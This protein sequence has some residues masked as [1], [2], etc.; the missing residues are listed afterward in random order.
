MSEEWFAAAGEQ[1]ESAA[2][3]LPKTCQLAKFLSSGGHGG[4]RLIET[5]YTAIPERAE[6]IVLELDVEVGQQPIHDIR[7]VER[8]AVTFL[9]SDQYWPEVLA[10]RVDFPTDVPH[11]FPRAD[12]EPRSLCLYEDSYGELK[13][14]WTAV[15][16]GEN[17]AMMV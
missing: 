17:F 10:L 1:V 2:L 7:P 5:R 16:V 3:R 14:R 11:L 6:T 15:K 13:L 9:E 8:I 12:D 4:A